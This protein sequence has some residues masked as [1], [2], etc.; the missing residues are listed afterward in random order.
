MMMI[1]MVTIMISSCLIYSCP[2]TVMRYA[3]AAILTNFSC[4]VVNDEGFGRD[5]AFV[6]G[7]PGDGLF[8]RFQRVD[9]VGEEGGG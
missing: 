6:T 9:E 4:S 8:L 7:A 1:M 2:F 5:G 3:T